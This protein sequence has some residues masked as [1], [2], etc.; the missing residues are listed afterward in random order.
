MP[1]QIIHDKEFSNAKNVVICIYIVLMSVQLVAIEGFSVSPLKVLAM[2]LTPLFIIRFGYHMVVTD[3]AFYGIANLILMAVCASFASPIVAWDRIGYR[4]MYVFMFILVYCI[5]YDGC[6]KLALIKRLLVVLMIAYGVIFLIQHALY[7]F[8]VRSQIFFLNY[9]ASITM[10]GVFKPNGLACEPSHSAR[11]ITVIYWGILKLS[12]IELGKRISFKRAFMDMP[13]CSILFFISMIAMGSATGMIGILLILLYFFN[14][15]FII[16]FIAFVGFI[17]M[18]SM[19]IENT[20]IRRLQNVF[21]SFFSDD[22]SETLKTKE[23]SGAV[24][25]MPFI[26]TFKM[27]FFSASTWIGQGSVSETNFLKKVFSESRYLGDITSFGLI[28][29]LTS[30]FFVYKCCIRKFFSI[31]TLLFLLLATFS[32]GSVYYTWLMLMIF[33]IVKYFEEHK[34][35][36]IA[37]ESIKTHEKE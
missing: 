28:S 11:I 37:T 7:L 2:L 9:Y 3:A 5:M 33:M 29:Y 20:Q 6:V 15:N 17:L 30:Q 35:N 25:I 26:N 19:E 12:E 16:F 4:A 21:N 27:D 13:Y 22:V 36:I 24:R 10:N 18:M 8:G 31:E 1:N 32:V 14:R 23:G 34:T